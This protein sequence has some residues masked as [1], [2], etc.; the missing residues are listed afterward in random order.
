MQRAID[1]VIKDGVPWQTAA[2]RF[3]VPRNTLKRRALDKNVHATKTKKMLGKFRPIFTDVQEKE[4]INHILD[5]E[6][7]FFGVTV[8][9]LQALACKLA[10]KNGI[11]HNFNH[12]KEAAGIDW[13]KGF[14]KRHPMIPLRKLEA[15]SAARAQAFNKRKV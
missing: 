11:S 10:V 2:K 1:A 15:T 12:E 7:R 9:D 5:M 13:V 6:V 8:A 3:Q 14:R 4:I